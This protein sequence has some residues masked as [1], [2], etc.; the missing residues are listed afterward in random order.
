MG[1][2]CGYSGGSRRV[3]V[4]LLFISFEIINSSPNQSFIIEADSSELA[5][6]H[7]GPDNRSWRPRLTS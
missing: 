4:W 1:Q 2:G 6:R 3:S 5:S 7:T